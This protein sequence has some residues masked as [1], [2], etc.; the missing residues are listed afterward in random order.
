[1]NRSQVNNT[2]L[3]SLEIGVR[4]DAYPIGGE[5]KKINSA[6]FTFVALD[7]DGTKIE[8]PEVIP[9]DDVD[10]KRFHEVFIF[11]YSFSK[12]KKKKSKQKKKLNQF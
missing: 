6:F 4:V 3:T 9:T 1:M 8:L 10:I 2:F 5:P 12:K 11:Y 7:H